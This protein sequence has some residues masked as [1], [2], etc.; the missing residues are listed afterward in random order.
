MPLFQKKPQISRRE[1]RETFKKT[2]IGKITRQKRSGMESEIFPRKYGPMISKREFQRASRE[3]RKKEFEEKDYKT[4][5][6]L[7]KKLEYLQK[8]GG[9]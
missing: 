4:K 9:K 2:P 8:L 6:E 3:L 5:L 1:L 7:K